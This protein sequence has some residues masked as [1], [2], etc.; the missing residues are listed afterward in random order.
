[1]FGLG[2]GL[3]AFLVILWLACIY[4]AV[5]SKNITSAGSVEIKL[6]NVIRYFLEAAVIGFLCEWGLRIVAK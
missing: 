5:T 2:M 4:T 6:I 1:M 3:F